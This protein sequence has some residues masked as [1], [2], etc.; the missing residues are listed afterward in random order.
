MKQ[1]GFV[2]VFAL[3]PLVVVHAWVTRTTTTTSSPRVARPH[4]H[5]QSEPPRASSAYSLLICHAGFGASDSKSK[6]KEAKLKPKQM[7]D[8][9]L[10]LKKEDKVPVGVRVNDEW[11][12]V[13]AVKSKNNKYTEIAVARQRG[14]LAEVRVCVCVCVCVHL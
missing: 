10:D 5:G 1:F 8:R 14:L 7:W 13:G 12:D 9:Y 2:L 4:R 3:L 11:F 6:K